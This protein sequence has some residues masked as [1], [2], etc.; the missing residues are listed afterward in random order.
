MTT[1][2]ITER[3][4]VAELASA[5]IRKAERLSNRHWTL[6]YLMQNPDWRG[7]GVVV[8]RDAQRGT[9]VLPA[10]GMETKVRFRDEPPV[11]AQRKL[12]VREVDLTSLTAYFQVRT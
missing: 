11:N 6:V 3:I 2:E 12:A 7:L 4:G 1:Q 5:N 9:V 10:L 8:E